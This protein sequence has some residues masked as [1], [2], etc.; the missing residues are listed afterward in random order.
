MSPWLQ[1]HED[2][3][4]QSASLGLADKGAVQQQGQ[5]GLED[6]NNV[7]CE[8]P[9]KDQTSPMTQ[10]HQPKDCLVTLSSQN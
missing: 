6:S 9:D 7:E 10:M 5:P 4:Q 8:F 2:N 3:N 1:H